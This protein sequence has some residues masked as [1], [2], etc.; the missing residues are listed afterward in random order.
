MLTPATADAIK[1][2]TRRELVDDTARGAITA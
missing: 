2:F 1:V